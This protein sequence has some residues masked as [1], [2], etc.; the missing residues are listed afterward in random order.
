MNRG[1]EMRVQLSNGLAPVDSVC[2]A[3]G[4]YLGSDLV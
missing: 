3:Q 4:S 1:Y 2:L